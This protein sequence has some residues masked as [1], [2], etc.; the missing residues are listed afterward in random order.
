[1]PDKKEIE[2]IIGEY[3]ALLDASEKAYSRKC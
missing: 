1:M 2:R 3:D